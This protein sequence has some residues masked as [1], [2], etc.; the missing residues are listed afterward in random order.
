MASW[1]AMGGWWMYLVLALTLAVGGIGSF[2]VIFAVI[3]VFQ[4]R[5]AVVGR[6]LSVI[7]LL[8]SASILA[9]GLLG[10]A[11]GWRIV[12]D[13]LPLAAPEQRAALAEQGWYEAKIPGYFGGIMAAGTGLL[14]LLAL[15]G[16][17]AAP[18]LAR[19]E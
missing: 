17:L 1:F 10:T 6:V 3:S 14:A 9:V 19:T 4:P 13:V 8:G 11:D 7:A 2:A 18:R 12:Q 5:L 15:A 16:S